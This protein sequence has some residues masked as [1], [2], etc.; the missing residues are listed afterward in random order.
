MTK[1][2]ISL[3]V[4]TYK[5]FINLVGLESIKSLTKEL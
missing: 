1:E 4:E 2:I 3:R 5:E